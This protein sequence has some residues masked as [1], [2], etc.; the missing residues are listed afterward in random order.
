VLAA[1]AFAGS[2]KA[3]TAHSGGL[4]AQ[5]TGSQLQAALLPQSDV[6]P[7]RSKTVPNGNFSTGGSLV[8][9][10]PAAGH[11]SCGLVNAQIDDSNARQQASKMGLTA[12][13]RRV[14]VTPA[15]AAGSGTSGVYGDYQEVYQ[16]AGPAQARDFFLAI[17]PCGSQ[18]SG[19]RVR[20]SGITHLSVGGDPAI[21][22]TLTRLSGGSPPRTTQ[23]VLIVLD[24]PDVFRLALQVSGLPGSALPS[25]TEQERLM[26]RLI[27]SVRTA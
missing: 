23:R 20:G 15:A 13:A 4:A 26:L 2:Y 1:G 3:V 25:L 19:S 9:S 18:P 14:N 6:F 7:G 5:L 21:T 27:E 12:A 22:Y 10:H 11:L 16:L 8:P 24:G 17:Q